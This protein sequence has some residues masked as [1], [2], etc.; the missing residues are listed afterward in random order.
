MPTR[1]YSLATTNADRRTPR[2]RVAHFGHVSTSLEAA[3]DDLVARLRYHANR[4]PDLYLPADRD[5]VHRTADRL[6][7]V[8][9]GVPLDYTTPDGVRFRVVRDEDLAEDPCR[10]L[11]AI[12]RTSEH[13][14]PGER[15]V[16]DAHAE[17][18]TGAAR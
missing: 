1:F 8:P 18:A 13:D 12:G 10:S 14:T 3:R 2:R 17:P 4:S 5:E 11:R 7:R 6:E 9:F 15:F 16:I